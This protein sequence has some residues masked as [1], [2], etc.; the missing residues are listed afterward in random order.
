MIQ[1]SGYPVKNY[2]VQTKDGYILELFRIP[3]GQNQQDSTND[4]TNTDNSDSDESNET[5]ARPAIML[6]H[7]LMSSAED[8]VVGG[9]QNSL[10]MALADKGYDVFL[11][12]SRGSTYG[13]HHV[14]L[15][16]GRDSAFW[17]F[18]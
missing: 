15:N 18:W 3:H 5:K 6:L 2:T 16:P 12:N 10:A 11:A 14:G 13:T 8:F 17:K 1:N 4:N 9:P 7:G